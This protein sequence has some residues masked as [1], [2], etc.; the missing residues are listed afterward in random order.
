MTKTKSEK[1]FTHLLI[2]TIVWKKKK[3]KPLFLPNS[4]RISSLPEIKNKIVFVV[5][6]VVVVHP[7]IFNMG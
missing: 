1:I 7:R 2:E 5:V 6:V 3:K 4:G